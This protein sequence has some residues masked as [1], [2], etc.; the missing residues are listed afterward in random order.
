MRILGIVLHHQRLAEPFVLHPSGIA[1]LAFCALEA[2][3]D[4]T[5]ALVFRH[6]QGLD[7][8]PVHEWPSCHGRFFCRHPYAGGMQRGK[9]NIPERHVTTEPQFFKMAFRQTFIAHAMHTI[10]LLRTSTP[11]CRYQTF[12]CLQNVKCTY[13]R[14]RITSARSWNNTPSTPSHVNTKQRLPR[15]H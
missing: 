2:F 4:S 13:D 11:A 14:R 9:I 3:V 8:I 5:F 1:F 7:A 6:W 12:H 15:D 10:K